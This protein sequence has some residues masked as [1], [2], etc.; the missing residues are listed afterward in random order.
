MRVAS[1]NELAPL[2]RPT[3]AEAEEAVRTLIAW[4][5]DDPSRPALARTPERVAEAFKEHF[6]GYGQ[7]PIAALAD[8]ILEEASGYD[9]L[10]LL[11]DI[12][13]ESHCEHHMVPFTGLA[14]VAYLPGTRLAGLSRLARAVE[15][16]AK[17]L[18]TQ[19]ALTAEIA[20]ALELALSPRG[21]AV[22]IEAEH[23]CMTTRGV[24][25]WGAR[26]VTMRF[27]GA[28]ETEDKLR[29][30]FITA[31]SAGAGGGR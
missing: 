13:V 27:R 21:V 24:H 7:D 18:Q 5:G 31:V 12:R 8:P 4:A 29:T 16:L 2:R 1:Q 26:A 19:E 25:Q 23:H 28:F 3:R 10:V 11:K 14:H 22:W 15:I 17:R 20:D 9:D 6:S 30:Q